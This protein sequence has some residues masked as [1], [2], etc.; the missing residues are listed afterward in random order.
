M[1][2]TRASLVVTAT[3]VFVGGPGTD[4]RVANA[5]IEEDLTSQAYAEWLFEGKRPSVYFAEGLDRLDSDG[6]EQSFGFIGLTNCIDR[7]HC[8][9]AAALKATLGPDA[10]EVG[11]DL[12]DAHLAIMWGRR[13]HTVAWNGDGTPTLDVQDPLAGKARAS[14]PADAEGRVLRKQ[15]REAASVYGYI[16]RGNP[17]DEEPRGEEPGASSTESPLSDIGIA[18][19]LAASYSTSIEPSNTNRCITNNRPEKRFKRLI[20]RERISIGKNRL[21]LDTELSRV[22]RKHT[23]AMIDRGTIYHSTAEV[24]RRRVTRW[25]VLGENVG[26]GGTVVSLH[27]AFVNSPAHLQNILYPTFRFVGVGVKKAKGR[28]W[29]TVIFERRKNPGTTLRCPG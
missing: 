21:R 29:V 23:K 15:V 27:D 18:G 3:L 7:S 9:G 24:L 4:L 14:R 10:F 12:G 11:P 8:I 22:A 20:N 28:M 1:H 13:R 17:E 6:N 2:F 19:V 26:V 25:R 16:A 5:Q